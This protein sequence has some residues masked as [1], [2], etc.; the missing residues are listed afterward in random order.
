MEAGTDKSSVN[1]AS[2]LPPDTRG[3]PMVTTLASL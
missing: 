2:I 3:E 1:L